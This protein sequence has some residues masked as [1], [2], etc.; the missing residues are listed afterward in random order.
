M[1]DF[2]RKYKLH[3]IPEAEIQKIRDEVADT[4]PVRAAR[5]RE[6]AR[7]KK[8]PPNVLDLMKRAWM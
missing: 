8:L 3:E 2:S 5:L 7:L 6:L 4:D 1:R